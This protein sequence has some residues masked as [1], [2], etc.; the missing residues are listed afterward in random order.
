MLIGASFDST[1]ASASAP[2]TDFATSAYAADYGVGETEAKRWLDRIQPIHD[3]LQAIRDAESG[4]VAG[5]GIDHGAQMIGWVLLTGDSAAGATALALAGTHTDIE[6]R[7][8]A[9]YTCVLRL[10]SRDRF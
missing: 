5:W 3:V 6:I 7:T 9:T 4:R 8:G 10:T 1:K 2:A